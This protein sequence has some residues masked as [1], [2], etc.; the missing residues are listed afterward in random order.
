[1]AKK[2]AAEKVHVPEVVDVQ[3]ENPEQA[4]IS[5][6][7]GGIAGFVAGLRQFM[8]GAADIEKN[9][10]ASLV[11]A[12]AWPAPTSKL[13]AERIQQ[14]I[15][16]ATQ[17]IKQAEDY[18][19]I[20]SV[21][22][23]WQRRLVALRERPIEKLNE[24]KAIG[25]RHVNAWNREQKRIAD[26]AAAKERREKE[27]EERERRE[28]ELAEVEAAAVKA[29]ESS[30]DLSPREEMFIDEFLRNNGNGQAAAKY[31]GYKDPLGQS[32]RLLTNDKI[33]KAIEAKQQAAA[34]RR[35]AE[36]VRQMP[37]EV[38]VEPVRAA[39]TKGTR[40]TW[41]A[42]ITDA[43]AFINAVFEGKHG[44]PRD[45]LMIDEAKVRE[46]GANMQAL[47]DRW[48]GVR[49]TKTTKTV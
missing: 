44:I 46:Y 42:E 5:S 26:E 48:P 10:E 13:E 29:E 7:G 2:K 22:Y 21:V 18:W 24:V 32:A 16:Q 17:D 23:R 9:A 12:K 38:E 3:P 30:P 34:L 35:Q 37:I 31:A 19:G 27:Q 14:G 28:R 8:V 47:I 41:G 1:M 33:K 49:H 43:Q 40:T 11:A 39:T 45:V 25:D 36:A 20:T 6:E 15:R 4:L